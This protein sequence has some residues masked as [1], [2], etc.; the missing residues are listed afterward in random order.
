MP[1]VSVHVVTHNS[2]STLETCL[3]AVQEQTYRDFAIHVIDNASQDGSLQIAQRLDVPVIANAT[4]LGYAAAHNHAIDSTDSAYVLTLNPDVWLERDFL[5]A[6]VAALDADSHL[7]SAAG[8]LMRVEHLGDVPTHLDGV[9][10]SMTRS[11]RQRLISEGLP[12]KQRP[13]HALSI[14]G[15]DGAAAFYRR[16]MLDDIRVMGEVFDTDFFM[17]K[18]D[19][20]VCW[21][22][23]LRGWKS[24]YVP[25]AVAQHVR[26]FRPGQRQGVTDHMRFLGVRNRYLLM[27]KNELPT[28]FWRDFPAIAA[29]DIG[30][31]AYLLLRERAS[32]R[33][34][35]SVL[36]LL[37][38]ILSKRRI[39][40]SSR[41]VT[42]RDI[43]TA[44]S[45]IDL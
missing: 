33:S 3:R 12:V 36:R 34:Y 10:I 35:P 22:A 11:R 2:A 19:I 16:A 4:N 23:Q 21:R 26:G 24:L 45:P 32:L 6:M 29:Y 42:W 9:G 39:I 7:G 31:L 5:R 27:L 38:R 41:V 44:F 37:P 25:G 14:F 28:H 15:P 18:E 1:T 40:Q 43:Q 17:H 30:I 20:D 13:T 8:C